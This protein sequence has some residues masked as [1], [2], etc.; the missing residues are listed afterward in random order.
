MPECDP[1]PVHRLVRPNHL[2]P[3]AS[4][5]YC[6]RAGPGVGT[7]IL[8]PSDTIGRSGFPDAR[9]RPSRLGR[10][11]RKRTSQSPASVPP[12][13]L[14]KRG[15]H[16]AR[17]CGRR[18]W[19]PENHQPGAISVTRWRKR[20]HHGARTVSYRIHHSSVSRNGPLMRHSWSRGAR[21]PARPIRVSQTRLDFNVSRLA[22]T[23]GIRETGSGGERGPRDTSMSA[24]GRTCVP[25][26]D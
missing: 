17:Y 16:A 15:T 12:S 24:T 9:S 8:M 3:T 19:P 10:S 11:R 14:Q 20:T 21:R 7:L 23:S 1:G 2:I 26:S 4:Q 25:R 18:R 5:Q 13:V 22:R 6:T